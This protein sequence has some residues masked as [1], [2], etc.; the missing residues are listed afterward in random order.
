MKKVWPGILVLNLVFNVCFAQNTQIYK[1]KELLYNRALDLFEK[2]LYNPA[3]SAF[4]DYAQSYSDE[5][6]ISAHYYKSLC[7]LYLFHPDAVDGLKNFQNNYPQN[8][9]SLRINFDLGTFF[10]Q[11]G[12]FS[13][14]CIY[15]RKV[16][17]KYLTRE[18]SVE[19]QFKL[20]YSFFNLQQFDEAAPYFNRVKGSNSKY[21][22]AAYY[23]S[24]IIAYKSGNYNQAEMDLRF[25]ESDAS[26]KNLIPE[27]LANIYYKQGEY[28]KLKKIGEDVLED[29]GVRNKRSIYMI[30]ADAYFNEGNYEKANE[31][32][33]NFNEGR[34]SLP[35]AGTSYRIGYTKFQLKNFEEAVPFLDQ[36][37]FRGND[38]L[39]QMAS[40]YLGRVHLKNDN[41]P[42]AEN[43]FEKA[44][45]LNINKNVQEESFFALAKLKF[46][47]RLRAQS[48]DLFQNYLEKY[49]RGKYTEEA[50]Q[51]LSEA[52]LTSNNYQA[53]IKH[54]ESLKIS[55]KVIDETYQ[56]VT[57]YRGVELFNDRSFEEA[58]SNFDKSLSKALSKEFVKLA[59]F[60]KGEALSILQN[61]DEAINSYAGV[62][63]N[64][65]S[66]SAEIFL[67]T[68]YGIGY[69][70]F[71]TKQYDKAL[72]HFSAYT[73][74]LE[75]AADK[76]NYGD[77]LVRLADCHLVLKNNQMAFNTYLRASKVYPDYQDYTFYR[78]GVVSWFL[79][80]QG[81]A[82][83]YLGKILADYKDSRYY[84]DALYEK[85]N[86]YFENGE[87]NNAIS[88]FTKL[89]ETQEVSPFIPYAYLNRGISYTNLNKPENSIKDYRKILHKYASHK[90]AIDAITGLQEALHSTGRDDEYEGDKQ[91][92]AR[93]NPESDALI[94]LDFEGAR[95]Q[96][97]AG[98]YKKAIDKFKSYLKDYGENSYFSDINYYLGESY[99]LINKYD[100]ALKYHL[101]VLKISNSNF[102]NKS[103]LRTADIQYDKEEYK[104]AIPKYNLLK[105]LART[106]NEEIFAWQGLMLSHYSLANYDSSMGFAQLITERGEAA[107]GARNKALLFLGKASRAIEKFDK[108]EEYFQKCIE[109]GDD[110]HAAEAFFNIAEIKY[111]LGANQKSIDL[112]LDLIGKYAHYPEW[113][114]AAF[115]L[116]A[117]NFFAMEEYFQARSTLESIIANS[118]SENTVNAAKE[119]LISVKEKEAIVPI[120]EIN[121]DSIE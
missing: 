39:V 62:F 53:A 67:K 27:L 55:N 84:D 52:Y 115:L 32:F 109:A 54:I 46:D 48:I 63:R 17:Y 22:N 38:S 114:D 65:N 8:P 24:G 25:L 41:I 73:D 104:E 110:V 107:F 95:N 36:A 40:F 108:A 76:M 3:R 21:G 111:I 105:Y 78:L 45:S 2:Q 66:S 97:F 7:G 44:S 43:A 83:K 58:V 79:G 68:R 91:K 15:L 74:A 51:Y 100:S 71:N 64:E 118:P 16:D 96:Y 49:P 33:D 72:P 14:A 69:A 56:K 77:A 1:D 99:Y 10:Y 18:E 85:A 89:I 120:E 75:S 13:D 92:F 31:Y 60:W 57:F 101:E 28:E 6:S 121:L 81:D 30:L 106:R 103:I 80:N 50:N 88:G 37:A 47:S 116:I 4:S 98:D 34:R 29:R 87:F 5:R 59:Y 61:Y 119:L 93:A 19:S 112:S 11:K 35:D 23:Y 86:I 117:K 94:T 90:T 20:A 12:N 42:Y 26:Y 9:H 113:N 102:L 70:Y 82:L